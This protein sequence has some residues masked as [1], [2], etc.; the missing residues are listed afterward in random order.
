MA[1]EEKKAQNEITIEE[2]SL[3]KAIAKAC[4]IFNTPKENLEYHVIQEATEGFLGFGKKKT[5]V[6]FR[7]LKEK[8]DDSLDGT[9]KIVVRKKG[10]MLKVD[11]PDGKGKKV[12]YSEIEDEIVKRAIKTFDKDKIIKEVEAPSGEWFKIGEYLFNP[13]FD[14]KCDIEI[15]EDKLKVYGFLV[16]PKLY[17]R[18][19]EVD[20]IVNMV[21]EKGVNYGIMEDKIAEMV[22]NEIYN[23]K[24]VIAQGKPPIKGEDAKIHYSFETEFSGPRFD[25]D[26]SGKVNYY[27]DL[28]MI[29]NVVTDQV[30]AKK[31]PAQKGENG[32]DVFNNVIE[33]KDGSDVPFNTGKNTYFS[34]DGTEIKAQIAGRALLEE[35]TITVEPVYEVKG[36]VSLKT[37]NIVFLGDVII[38]GN[39]EDGLQVKAAG[40]IHV[41]GTIGKAEIEANG[42]IIVKQGVLGKDEGTLK[43]GNNIYAKYFEHTNIIA[44]N[45]VIVDEIILHSNVDAKKVI[46][47]GT[48]GMIVGGRIRVIEEVNAKVIGS[49]A[50]ADT[51]IEAGIDPAAKEK[52]NRFE[53][54]REATEESL[55]KL[56]VNLNTL[57]N[58]KKVVSKLSDEK[59]LMLQRMLKAKKELELQLSELEKDIENIR[60][61][62]SQL[63]AQGKISAMDTVHV[64]TELVIRNA[65]LKP[66]NSFTYVTFVYD[67]GFIRPNVYVPVK[68]KEKT[69]K[70]KADK[71]LKQK[72]NFKK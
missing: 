47:H 72:R 16:P 52:L 58:Q 37:G 10:I 42:D 5:K 40:S 46:C 22:D 31:I 62:L 55:N 2:E 24:V 21:K 48:R 20:E 53:K 30:L 15:S 23:E 61:Y 34:D 35:E 45:E 65:I 14:S 6:F 13:E 28:G 71:T 26:E 17:G 51:R 64:G 66:K 49:S 32:I 9:F 44:G 27:S 68:G 12:K 59:E 69:A 4:K 41:G 19:L 36:D 11:P 56:V 43:A 57:M 39:V 3:E 63:N 67:N 54:E 60:T 70:G 29:Q 1:S 50:E 33:A 8:V 25:V 38:S 7:K 18:V